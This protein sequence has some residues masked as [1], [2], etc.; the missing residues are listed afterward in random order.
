[1]SNAKKVIVA[2]FLGWALDAFD[3]FLLVFLLSD[4]AYAFS[5]TVAA[6]SVAIMLTLG[7]RPIGAFIFGRV[8]DRYGRRPA[9]MINI[10]LYSLLGFASAFS[11]NLTVLLLLRSLFGIAMGGEW[12]VGAALAIESVPLKARGVVSGLLQSG[13][14]LGYLLASLAF[15]LLHDAI[16]WRGMFM[17]SALPAL[18]VLYI[19]RYIPESPAWQALQQK[20]RE[21]WT[22]SFKAHWK[23]ALYAILL[24]TG[25]NFLSHGSQD[26]YPTFLQVQHH[27]D[28]HTVGMIALIYNVGAILGGIGFGALSQVL[29]RR[30]TI[31]I[32]LILVLL[33]LPLWTFHS[34]ALHLAIAAFFMQ[35]AIQGAWGVVPVYLN[36]LSPSSMRATFPGVTYQIGNL[37]AS[38]NAVLQAGLAQYWDGAY[39]YALA[40]VVGS[41]AV[42]IAVVIFFGKERK[43]VSFVE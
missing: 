26:L 33:L 39:N 6:V 3:F 4:I 42:F 8:A 37:L 38:I 16:G 30:Y 20:P 25:F 31:L 41:A 23:L 18:L 11:P 19:R 5:T 24:M 43:N 22:T 27:L 36:E 40:V 35:V 14:P 7:M 10:A 13:Y 15:F 29:G 34:Q 12:G 32:A 2:C 9:L 21:K 28:T 17:L 1:M